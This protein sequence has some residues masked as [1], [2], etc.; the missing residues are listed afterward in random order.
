MVDAPFSQ[1]LGNKLCREFLLK[2]KLGALVKLPAPLND[3]RLQLAN[4]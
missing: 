1:L 4:I 3:L 2:T